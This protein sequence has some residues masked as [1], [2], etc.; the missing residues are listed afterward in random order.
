MRDLT[1]AFKAEFE[2]H[3]IPVD[4]L[5]VAGVNNVLSC[6][7]FEQYMDNLEAFKD[8]LPTIRT[9]VVAASKRLKEEAVELVKAVL[10]GNLLLG[11]KY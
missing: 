1:R 4:A 6:P 5:V 8:L 3:I 7:V 2:N 10:E 9:E 11:T